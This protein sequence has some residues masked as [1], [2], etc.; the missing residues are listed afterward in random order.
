MKKGV[1]KR[2]LKKVIDLAKKTPK[3]VAKKSKKNK[4]NYFYVMLVVVLIIA[5]VYALT[6]SNDQTV[7][8]SKDSEVVATVNGEVVT[9]DELDK[10]YR[11]SVPDE[12]KT[13]FT[14]ESFLNESIIPQRLV[15]QEANK[16]GITT[17]D[18][19]VELLFNDFL[20]ERGVSLE[21]FEESLNEQGIGIE[22][23][24]TSFR[25]NIIITKLINQTLFSG[26]E[27]TESEIRK[28]Y[29]EH[30]ELENIS[31]DI[32]KESIRN[33]LIYS[34]QSRAL[35]TYLEQLRKDA[36]IEILLGKAII[37]FKKTDNEI[38][39]EDEKPIIRLY[40]TTDCAGCE[41]VGEAF[42]SVAEEYDDVI[43]YHWELDTGDNKLTSD[44]EEGI[45]TSEIDIFKEFSD[46]KVPVLVFGCQYARIGSYF[47]DDIESEKNEFR[48]VIEELIQ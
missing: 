14:K 8:V 17:T 48:L 24:K 45:P 6:Y 11:I 30:D 27:V 35:E 19:E 43:A 9:M 44:K 32:I 20:E 47:G 22:E 15:L 29:A 31:Y 46:G 34:K 2:I 38:C 25:D 37:S 26:I 39:I 12:L 10:L 16:N 23:V 18:A 42:D 5:L 4:I 41:S 40:S 33:Q 28:F 1:L 21:E 13:M 3:K 36:D 7:S